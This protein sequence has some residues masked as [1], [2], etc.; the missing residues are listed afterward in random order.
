MIEIF[1]IS[2]LS[3][4]ASPEKPATGAPPQGGAAAMPTAAVLGTVH[5]FHRKESFAYSYADLGAQILNDH[6]LKAMGSG[7][8]LEVA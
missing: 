2:A 4:S 7:G 5:G 1:F 3:I 8:R 6:R